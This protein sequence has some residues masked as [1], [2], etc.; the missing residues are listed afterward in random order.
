MKGG[1]QLTTDELKARFSMLTMTQHQQCSSGAEQMKT[2]LMNIET[3][4]AIALQKTN[5]SV[6]WRVIAEMVVGGPWRVQH[7]NRTAIAKLVM[8]TEGAQYIATKLQPTLTPFHKE[9]HKRTISTFSGRGQSCS[10]QRLRSLLFTRTKN[11]FIV[12][13]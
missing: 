10:G 3:E 6:G 13:S 4:I 11:G 9:R 5:G 12:W 1:D 8:S 2:L 7:V